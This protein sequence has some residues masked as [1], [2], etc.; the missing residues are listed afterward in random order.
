MK[1][2]LR[3]I[4]IAELAKNFKDD[5]EG[6]V[7]GYSGKLD[8]RPPYQREFVYKDKQRAAVIDTVLK[9]FP[10]N[11]M[12]W[13]VREDGTFEI[14]DGQQR[15]ISICQYI[16][17]DFS[18]DNLYIQNRPADQQQKINDYKLTV[19]LCSG[20]D[21]ERLDWFR[22]IN[23]AG[24]KLTEQEL[25][26]AVYAGPWVSDAKRYFSRI[27]CPA[28]GLAGDYMAGVPIRQEYFETVIDWISS[29]AIEQHMATH[30]FDKDAGELWNYFQE[31]MA[32]VQSSFTSYRSEM[33]GLPWGE[34]F[35]KH[36]TTALDSVNLEAQ[37]AMLMEDDDVS[38]KRGIYAYLLTKDERHLNIRTFDIKQ[39]REAYERQK[40]ICVK[41]KKKFPLEEM[42]ADHI[43][44]WS[45]KGKTVADN[46]QMLCKED[47]RRKSNV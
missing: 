18:V 23:I 3:S 11:V 42:E 19:Y 27:N 10:L 41:C 26:N 1:I 43:T 44:P 4:T 46:C 12:Y 2:E 47:N 38:N 25:R 14:I 33:K 36:K 5:K 6:G 13:S 8:I 39:K 34:Y 15:T 9:G 40:G 16:N 24:E 31:V 7:T 32:W 35:N 29:G 30:Q 20:T 28:Q 22:T 21:S 45:K 37:V 17:G